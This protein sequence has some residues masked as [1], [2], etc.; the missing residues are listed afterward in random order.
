[1]LPDRR[2]GLFYGAQ[3]VVAL[4]AFVGTAAD[5]LHRALYQRLT[6]PTA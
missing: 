6:P 4:K 2:V 3:R 1:M 5:H